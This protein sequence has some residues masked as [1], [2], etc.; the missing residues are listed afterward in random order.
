MISE[1]NSGDHGDDRLPDRPHG[2]G[3]L[4]VARLLEDALDGVAVLR[5]QVREVHGTEPAHRERLPV[6]EADLLRGRHVILE[7]QDVLLLGIRR[8]RRADQ[9]GSTGL[10][11][12]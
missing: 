12:M 6:G 8:I 7:R 9:A 3:V 11:S 1:A 4:A 2:L 10:P 5:E